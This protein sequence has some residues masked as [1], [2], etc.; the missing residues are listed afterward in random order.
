MSNIFSIS[1]PLKTGITEIFQNKSD[2]KHNYET[3]LTNEHDEEITKRKKILYRILEEDIFQNYD[4]IK[5]NVL[6]EYQNQIITL[7]SDAYNISKDVSQ[8]ALQNYSWK[9]TDFVQATKDELILQSK[10][11]ENQISS[12]IQM[13]HPDGDC[14]CLCCFHTFSPESLFALPCRHFACKTCWKEHIMVKSKTECQI[15]CIHS[16]NGCSFSFPLEVLD[17]F[18]ENIELAKQFEEKVKNSRIESS[19]E[20]IHCPLSTC[21]RLIKLSQGNDRSYAKCECGAMICLHCKKLD[22]TPFKCSGNPNLIA[23]DDNDLLNRA[24]FQLKHC[25]SCGILCNLISGCNWTQCVGCKTGFCWCC[26]KH[27]IPHAKYP[28]CDFTTHT[29]EPFPPLQGSIEEN[30]Q[31]LLVQDSYQR[32]LQQEKDDSDKLPILIEKLKVTL[33][34]QN[35]DRGKV[36]QTL[37]QISCIIVSSRKLLKNSFKYL[38]TLDPKKPEFLKSFE[39]A[40]TI[41]AELRKLL[42]ILASPSESLF[43]EVDNSKKNLENALNQIYSKVQ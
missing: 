5:P 17:C 22:H 30:Q 26:G 1:E 11:P 7:I 38:Y 21:D 12:P 13:T 42:E 31:K 27:P 43:N 36:E 23:F 39:E 8:V 33:M 25:P 10:I 14:E 34:E 37:N 24:L 19:S 3:Q 4:S 29:Y 41:E 18:W 32:Q 9:I 15:R 20:F 2:L 16:G 35:N 40:K 6:I 28:I